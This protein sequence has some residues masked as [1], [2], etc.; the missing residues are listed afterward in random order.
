M[1]VIGDYLFRF[2][3]L[4]FC[5]G[6]LKGGPPQKNCQNPTLTSTQLVGVLPENDFAYTPPPPLT[7]TQCYQSLSC[8]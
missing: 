8:Y 7:Q 5:V 3:S 6:A 2:R 1:G 4:N